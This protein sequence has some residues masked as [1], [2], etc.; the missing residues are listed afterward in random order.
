MTVFGMWPLNI[1]RSIEFRKEIGYINLLSPIKPVDADSEYNQRF[2][3]FKFQV[4]RARC[5]EELIERILEKQQKIK[6]RMTCRSMA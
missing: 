6:S 2:P 3:S 5:V 4:I 1:N